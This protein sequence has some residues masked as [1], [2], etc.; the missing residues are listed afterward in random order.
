MRVKVTGYLDTNDMEPQHVDESHDMGLSE[1]GFG[2]YVSELGL[3]DVQFEAEPDAAEQAPTGG[4]R[5]PE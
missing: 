4:K 3:D 1:E 5:K 2:F